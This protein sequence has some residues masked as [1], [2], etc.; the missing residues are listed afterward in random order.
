MPGREQPARAAGRGLAET[1]AKATLLLFA[2]ATLIVV[3]DWVD[4]EQNSSANG[5]TRPVTRDDVIVAI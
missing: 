5:K 3:N 4:R 1:L 2:G